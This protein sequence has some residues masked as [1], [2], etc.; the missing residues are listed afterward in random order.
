[1]APGGKMII[2]GYY[3]KESMSLKNG[4]K[5]HTVKGISPMDDRIINSK[6]KFNFSNKNKIYKPN[7][8]LLDEI[9][10]T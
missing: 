7:D 4:F 9:S 5:E 3:N 6:E 8:N 1:M 2:N 10:K